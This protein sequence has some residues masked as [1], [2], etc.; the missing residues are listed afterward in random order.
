[1]HP[2]APAH[3]PKLPQHL[4]MCVNLDFKCMLW[5]G[6]GGLVHA[7]RFKLHVPSI[8]KQHYR[9]PSRVFLLASKTVASVFAGGRSPEVGVLHPSW[10]HQWQLRIE[11]NC[12]HAGIGI[13]CWY[14]GIRTHCWYFSIETHR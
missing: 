6:K 7:A 9:R 8:A 11:I 1:M 10:Y 12:R 14:F 2:S 13:Y 5:L 4:C 3:T